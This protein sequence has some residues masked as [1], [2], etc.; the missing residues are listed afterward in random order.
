MKARQ[1][2]EHSCA[3]SNRAF[4]SYVK[5]ILNPRLY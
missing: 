1:K 5:S 2:I 4:I 3:K